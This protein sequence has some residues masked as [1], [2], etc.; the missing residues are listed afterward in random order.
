MKVAIIGAGISGLYLAWRLSEKGNEVTVFEKKEKIGSE[1]CSGLFS[2]RILE[3]IPE[4]RELIQNEINFVFLHFPKKTI[5]VEFSKKF[6]VMSHL[7]L[8]K[9]ATSLARK[10]G[11]KIVLNHNISSLPQGFDRIIGCDGA[12]S[13]VRKDLGLPEPRYRLGMLGFIREPF[14]S[15]FVETWPCQDGFIWKIPRSDEIEYGIIAEPKLAKKI[16][17]SFLKKNRI[18]LERI[19]SKIVPQGLIISKNPSITLCGDAAGIT[20]PW[21][22]GG[23]IWGSTAADILLKSFP[24]FLRY[25]KAVRGFFVPRVIFSKTAIKLV[26][27]FGFKIPLLLPKKTRMESDFLL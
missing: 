15:D 27:F 10:S 4:S 13:F 20:K 25:R 24:D 11:A 21:S 1:V 8:D 22:G 26:N 23:V 2:N 9:L 14:P 12:N 16:F 3:F 17:D 19:K 6:F 5:K 7:E 18:S